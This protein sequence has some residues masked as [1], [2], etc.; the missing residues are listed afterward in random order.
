MSVLPFIS[1]YDYCE[2]DSKAVSLRN[3]SKE[4]WLKSLAVLVVLVKVVLFVHAV[5]R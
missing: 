2:N 5:R 3:K 4:C 1:S